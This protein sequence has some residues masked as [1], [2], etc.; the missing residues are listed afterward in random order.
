MESYTQ[1]V[2]KDIKFNPETNIAIFRFQGKSNSIEA[3]V[4]EY[5]KND[6]GQLLSLVLDRLIHQ[7]SEN[8]FKVFI[9]KKWECSFSISGCIT[10][11][12]KRDIV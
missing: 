10:S 5:T 1:R 2:I 6:E 4:L 7:P 3:K 11:E 12:L 9:N 8:G